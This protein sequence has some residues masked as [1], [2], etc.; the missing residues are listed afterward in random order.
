MHHLAQG[1]A[2]LYISSLIVFVAFGPVI[3]VETS[4][5]GIETPLESFE[6]KV[7]C[8]HLYYL[9]VGASTTCSDVAWL[10]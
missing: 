7:T 2:I 6:A 9:E 4:S 3:G 8:E 5:E 10:R 1:V